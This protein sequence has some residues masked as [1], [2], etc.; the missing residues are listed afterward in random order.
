MHELCSLLVF[1]LNVLDV[2]FVVWF[3]VCLVCFVVAIASGLH[4]KLLVVPVCF[5]QTTGLVQSFAIPVICSPIAFI[6]VT[7][8]GAS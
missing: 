4:V 1:A 5:M 7:G 3:C 2:L 8:L 6:N